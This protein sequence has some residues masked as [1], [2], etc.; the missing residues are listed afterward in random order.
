MSQQNTWKIDIENLSDEQVVHLLRQLHGSKNHE[1]IRALK[2]EL[3]RRLRVQDIMKDEEI[4]RYLCSG[5]PRG[6][7]P[8][9]NTIAKEW[10]EI[11]GLSEKEFKRIADAK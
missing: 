8:E 5:V 10:A 9:L 3:L 6:R 1:T 2:E 4:I 7:R 11:F